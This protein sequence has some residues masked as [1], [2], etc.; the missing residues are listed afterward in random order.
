MELETLEKIE[1]GRSKKKKR[2]W[3]WFFFAIF[4][5]AAAS[6]MLFYKASFTFSQM[7]SNQAGGMFPIS[8]DAPKIEKDPDR[9]N[10][11]LLGLRGQEDPN[12]GL[13]T[14]T[15]IVLSI[16]QSTGQMAMISIPRDLYVKMPT[17]SGKNSQTMKE[18]INFAY[19]L[20]EERLQAGGLV[21]A[22][23]AVQSVTGLFIDHVVSV[24]FLAF[25]EI[26]DILGGIDITLDKPF[27]ETTQFAKEILLELPAGENHLNGSTT[28]Y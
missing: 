18:K 2:F 24:D 7:N 6:G 13:L 17:E 12:G 20:G 10:I 15:M 27:K 22:K 26:V 16:K 21:Y 23:V 5:L 19:A 28:L 11:L 25:K 8:E 4:V 9:I 14:D 3:V 1:Q